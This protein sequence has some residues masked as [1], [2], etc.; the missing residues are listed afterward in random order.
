MNFKPI[1]EAI[2]TY[3]HG[4]TN[5]TIVSYIMDDISQSL[6]LTNRKGNDIKW[7]ANRVSELV[8]KNKLPASFVCCFELEDFSDAVELSIVDFLKQFETSINIGELNKNLRMLFDNQHMMTP[9]PYDIDKQTTPLSLC[10][11]DFFKEHCRAK[12]KCFDMNVPSSPIKMTLMAKIVKTVVDDKTSTKFIRHTR[13]YTIEEKISVNDIYGTMADRIQNAFDDFY[14][15]I[16]ACIDIMSE[17]NINVKNSFL[18]IIRNL[19]CDYLDINGID[20]TDKSSIKIKSAEA[21]QWI[22]AKVCKMLEKSNDNICYVDEVPIYSFA[23]VIYAFYK[24]RILLKVDGE[25]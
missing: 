23:L 10:L 20:L 24:C 11:Y 3:S 4:L 15:K 13:P 8:S 16:D 21:I 25:E 9:Y 17:E 19:Y 6:N 5:E 14:D 22:C 1:I 2:K 7:T 18:T 12:L